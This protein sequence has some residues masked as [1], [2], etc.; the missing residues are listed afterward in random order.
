MCAREIFVSSFACI[1]VV[2]LHSSNSGKNR[3]CV[4]INERRW[5]HFMS[6][7]KHLNESLKPTKE[8]ISIYLNW[9]QPHKESTFSPQIQHFH[10]CHTKKTKQNK[11]AVIA[12]VITELKKN[13]QQRNDF[14]VLCVRCNVF[15]F[16]ILFPLFIV[17]LPW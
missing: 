7:D 3:L 5:L 4:M 8:N 15:F 13:T 2:H 10:G 6:I 12:V 1:C 17:I 14:Y 16:Y 9:V 11:N